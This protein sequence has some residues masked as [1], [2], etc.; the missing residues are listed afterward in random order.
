[1]VRVLYLLRKNKVPGLS[2]SARQ[3]LLMN[4][5]NRLKKLLTSKFFAY[6]L[7]VVWMGLIFFMSH[8]EA[9]ASSKLSSGL[10]IFM[11]KAL[12]IITGKN[13]M[14]FSILHFLSRKTAH[15]LAYFVLGILI[16]RALP[17]SSFKFALVSLATSM[18][19]ACSDEF[20]QTF[21][22]GRSGE[23]R[24]VLLDTAGALLG[25]VL[26][27]IVKRNTTL[28]RDRLRLKITKHQP[29]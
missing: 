14:D 6:S 8:Q 18:L 3:V 9:S 25:V 2:P 15:F 24:D 17:S 1:M 26:Y 10:A 29:I 20:H 23:A 5:K 19:Y 27:Y 12:S 11:S 21:V 16:Y 22:L 28:I 4:T 13:D 7:V